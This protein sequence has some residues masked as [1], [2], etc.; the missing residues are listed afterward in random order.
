MRSPRWVLRLLAAAALAAGIGYLPLRVIGGG[1]IQRARLLTADLARLRQ[2]VEA[3]R[4]E[5]ARL[6]EEAA[7]L[8]EDPRAIERVARDE[9]GWVREGEIVF[10]FE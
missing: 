7:G 2:K 5:N 3:Q 10:Q 8:R 6:R 4:Q 9:L 1:G